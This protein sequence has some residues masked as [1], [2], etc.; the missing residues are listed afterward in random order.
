MKVNNVLVHDNFGNYCLD[1]TMNI[2]QDQ[3]DPTLVFNSLNFVQ[4]ITKNYGAEQG[5]AMWDTIANTVDRR[6]KLEVFK[7]MMDSG[8]VEGRIRI[9]GAYPSADKIKLIKTL[10][11]FTG[12]GLKDAKDAVDSLHTAGTFFDV[13]VAYHLHARAID[14]FRT[15]GFVL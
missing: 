7:A 4:A 6:L 10:R 15:A 14:A 13:K 1:I 11:E 8:Q 9:A 2:E 12:Y 3:L 5:M